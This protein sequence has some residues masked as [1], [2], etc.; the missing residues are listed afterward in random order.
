[1]NHPSVIRR[2]GLFSA[3]AAAT[4]ALLVACGGGS[5]SGDAAG[6]TPTTP[7]TPITPPVTAD[8]S[9]QTEQAAQLTCLANNFLATLSSSQQSAVVVSLTASNA[10]QRWSNLPVGMVARSGLPLSSLDAKAKAAALT[11]LRASLTA[12]GQTTMDELR[13]ADAYL[14]GLTGGYGEDLYYIA[15]LGAPS[16][17]S[18]WILQ[19][20]GHH[21][22]HHITVSG[23]VLGATPMFVAVEPTAWSANGVEHAPLASRRNA[24]LAMLNGLDASQQAAAKLPQAYDDLLVRPQQDGKF[25]SVR[26]GLQ[27]SQL[28]A[29]QQALV[30]AAI[31]SYAAD[32]KTGQAEAYVSDTALADTRVAWAG[33][34]DLATRGA[35]VRIDGPSVWIEFSVQPGIVIR[36]QNHYH[37]VW[38]DKQLD[39]GGLFKF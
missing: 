14:G 24:L 39:Y 2:A 25:P 35:Y 33:Y 7:T 3:I 29:T 5:D 19:F 30:K 8:C 27:V 4:V 15:L 34:T 16:T 11:L 12:Q 21:Y 32:A 22:T 28:S 10:T 31:L 36:T 18:S 23:K 9:Q 17:T 1:M 37:S 20:T 38:R 26:E 6:A 13:S